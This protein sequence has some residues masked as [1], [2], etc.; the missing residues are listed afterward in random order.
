MNSFLNDLTVLKKIGVALAAIIITS[1]CVSAT[2]WI[3]QGKLAKSAAITT[4]TYEVMS[5]L[6]DVQMAMVNQ[7]TGMR[8]YL[9]SADKAFLEPKLK[10][11]KDVV[12]AIAAIRELTSDNPAQQARLNEVEALAKTWQNDIAGKELALMSD[13]ATQQQA[14]D[15]E[16]SGAGK[17]SMDALRAKVA[18][19]SDEESSLLIARNNAAQSDRNLIRLVTVLSGVIVLGIS[20]FSLMVI[21]GALV[22]PLIALTK[23]MQDISKGA[24]NIA[25]PGT[26]RKDELGDMSRAFE[27]NADRIARLASER[28]EAEA[29]QIR[30]RRQGMLELADQFE[31]N[32]GGI[33]ELVSSAAT[34]MQATA[35]QLTATAQQTSSQAQ[36]VSAA[37]EEAST[38][39]SSV[40]S[41][42]EEL[43]ASVAEISRQVER[44][45]SKSEAAV[46]E[47]QSTAIIVSELSEAAARISDI[48]VLISGIAS[49]TNLLAL[50]ATIESARAGEAGKGFAVVASEVKQLASQTGKATDDITHQI[51]AIQETTARA[52]KAI[53]DISA[54]I[55]EIDE[56]ASVIS[57]AVGQQ[58]SAT[59]E[60]VSSVHQASAGTSEV[61]S[62]ITG[63]AR[64]A[65]ETG[66]GASQVYSASGELTQQAT[67][68]QT[69]LQSFLATVRAA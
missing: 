26:E 1:L 22:K 3:V 53:S 4:H 43:G 48:V 44:S 66:L 18:Q 28:N 15:L 58:S 34:E 9:V 56:T 12:T 20:A 14:R 21:N 8:G 68:L 17:A 42:A 63:V 65:E 2:I 45:A 61:T 31:R 30:E 57:A 23:A 49:Q 67:R 5:K 25:V 52:V 60:I 62:N 59:R 10:G 29:R 16:I 11:E 50:N 32:V 19:M 47:T 69:E 64:A 41:S 46:S 37:A 36:S 27:A 7:E 13:P 51:A 38:N 55:S 33:V 24:D 54:S 40:A 35:S 6:V 39:V